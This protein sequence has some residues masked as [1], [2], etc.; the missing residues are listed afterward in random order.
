MICIH[1]QV[2]VGTLLAFTMVAISV[3]ILRYVP[4]DVVPIPSSLQEAID[5]VSSKYR[6]TTSLIDSDADDVDAKAITSQNPVPVLV[7]K[8][9][10]LEDPLLAK[11]AVQLNCKLAQFGILT[12]STKHLMNLYSVVSSF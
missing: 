8:Q 9:S 11:E 3:L 12:A 1:L 2:S 6:T 5:S 7:S 4:P 10:P